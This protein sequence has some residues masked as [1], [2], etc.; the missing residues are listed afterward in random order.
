MARHMRERTEAVNLPFE[1]ELGRI[2][3]LRNPEEPHRPNEHGFLY[4]IN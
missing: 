2:E 3:G 4:G 1:D